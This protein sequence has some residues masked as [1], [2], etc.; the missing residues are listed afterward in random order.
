M[1]YNIFEVFQY[2]SKFSFSFLIFFLPEV[3]LPVEIPLFVF[4]VLPVIIVGVS[5]AF[6]TILS[7]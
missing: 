7:C 6:E 4:D 1:L 2:Q 5:L 3:L